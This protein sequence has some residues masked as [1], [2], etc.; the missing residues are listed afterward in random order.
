MQQQFVYQKALFNQRPSKQCQI[1]IA[2]TI[3]RVKTQIAKEIRYVVVQQLNS[4]QDIIASLKE[5]INKV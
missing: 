3:Q 2:E 5:L 1:H 4:H